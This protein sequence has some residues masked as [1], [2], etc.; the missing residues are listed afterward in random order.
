M[1]QILC[2]TVLLTLAL[3][4]FAQ[5]IGPMMAGRNDAVMLGTEQGLFVL[6]SGTL[7]KLDPA[8]LMPAMPPFELFGA[9]PAQPA[10]GD[11][12]AWQAYMKAMLQ[13]TAPALL[14][15]HGKDLLVVIGENFARIDQET[16]GLAVGVSFAREGAEQP[17]VFRPEPV[18]QYVVLGD[19]LYLLRDTETIAINI[20]DG[21]LLARTPL[22]PSMQIRPAT[23]GGRM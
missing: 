3:G 2:L 20:E 11:Q 7:A 22:P 6:K 18:P 13:R 19:V 23:A 10:G 15:P 16:F 8:T 14:I 4:A 1:K 12:E 5:A 21:K 9:M 17:M